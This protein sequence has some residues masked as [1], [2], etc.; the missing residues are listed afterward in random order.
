[1][2]KRALCGSPG[3]IQINGDKLSTVQNY[4]AKLRNISN[5][6]YI[7][8]NLLQDTLIYSTSKLTETMKPIRWIKGKLIQYVQIKDHNSCNII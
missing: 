5:S 2:V 1:M 7:E 4:L 6:G 3:F 8:V